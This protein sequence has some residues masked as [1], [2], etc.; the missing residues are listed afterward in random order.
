MI[1]KRRFSLILIVLLCV[2]YVV[3][4]GRNAWVSDDAYIT[5]RTVDNF[6]NGLGLTWN[7]GERVQAYT[8]PLWMFLM[9]AVYVFTREAFYTSIILSI[10]VSAS[11]VFLLS[12]KVAKST[13]V[14]C[15]AIA[16]LTLSKAFVDYST[17]G[18]EN[19]LSHL[20][21][22]IFFWLFLFREENQKNM[23]HLGFIAGLA[24]LTRLDN[25]LLLAPALAFLLWKNRNRKAWASVALGFLP[26]VVWESFSLFYY[27]LLLPNTAY[28][29]LATGVTWIELV[30]Q[31]LYYLWSSF[32]IDPLTGLIMVAAA[33]VPVIKKQWRLAMVAAGMVLYLVYVVRVGG[34]FMSGRFLTAPFLVGVLVI[35]QYRMDLR[36]VGWLAPGLAVLVIGLSAGRSPVYTTSMFGTGDLDNLKLGHGIV[37]E[38]GWYFSESS[39]LNAFGGRPMPTHPYAQLGRRQRTPLTA[40]STIGYY[41]YFAGPKTYVIDLCGLADP[42]MARLPFDTTQTWRIGHIFRAVP[43]GYEKTVLSGENFIQDPNLREYYDR[44]ALVIRGDLFSWE[45]LA[46]IARLNLGAYDHLLAAYSGD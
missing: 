36:K 42:L 46:T 44:L 18:L 38:R 23:L 24:A 10:V 35:S 37:D 39:L 40:R 19:P 22:V 16:A 15:I 41:G 29:K 34:C 9:S 2:V 14:S 1:V 17:S 25:L 5:F 20:L 28:A 3:V 12:L 13:Y 27:G 33:V 11:A 6:V 21:I 43:K 26:L 4:V 8:H 31:G 30:R 45:R 32:T 7:A